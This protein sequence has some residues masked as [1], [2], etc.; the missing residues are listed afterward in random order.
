MTYRFC[1]HCGGELAASSDGLQA[2]RRLPAPLG[3]VGIYDQTKYWRRLCHDVDSLAATPTTEELVEGLTREPL[4]PSSDLPLSSIV[5]L[6]LD[7]EVTPSGSAFLQ[8]VVS[9]GRQGPVGDLSRLERLGYVVEGGKVGQVD[10]VPVGVTYRA[11]EYWGGQRQHRR[12]HLAQP[13]YVNPSRHGDPFFMDDRFVAFGAI[14]RDL[15]QYSASMTALI[16]TLRKG[17]GAASA[18]NPLLVDVFWMGASESQA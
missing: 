16:E 9:D 2:R 3:S 18:G 7:R 5:H 17:F 10:G 8:S 6:V 14:W 15:D 4:P 1:P 13:I 12:W 11:L